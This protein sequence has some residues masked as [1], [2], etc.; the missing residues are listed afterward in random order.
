MAVDPDGRGFVETLIGN[1]DLRFPYK[2]DLRR[3]RLPHRPPA[4]CLKPWIHH[5]IL[6]LRDSF[7]FRVR[8]DLRLSA[9]YLF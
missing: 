3:Q 1:P 6:I 9:H 4:Y 8:L 2:T 7:S 5:L